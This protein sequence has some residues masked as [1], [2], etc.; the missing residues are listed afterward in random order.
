MQYTNTSNIRCQLFDY[1]DKIARLQ[2][3][4]PLLTFVYTLT[5][6]YSSSRI[7]SHTWALLANRIH[8]SVDNIFYLLPTV[9]RLF[10]LIWNKIP[11]GIFSFE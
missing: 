11:L 9:F 4:E 5:C 3:I 7:Y 1:I 2:I 6:Y 8:C 10:L